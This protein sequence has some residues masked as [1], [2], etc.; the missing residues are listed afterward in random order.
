[1]QTK[2]TMASRYRPLLLTTKALY[3][4]W[5]RLLWYVRVPERRSLFVVLPAGSVKTRA[6]LLAV[7]KGYQ[8]RGGTVRVIEAGTGMERYYKTRER[9]AAGRS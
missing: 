6:C 7:A 8:A 1:M 4:R 2:R 5:E 3:P 9:L